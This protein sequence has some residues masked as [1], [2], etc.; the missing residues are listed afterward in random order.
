MDPKALL[1]P[2]FYNDL[3]VS[4]D[5]TIAFSDSSYRYSRSQNR[6]E[7]LDGAPRGRLFQYDPLTAQL[8][9]VLCG[10]HFP[11]GVQFLPPRTVAY[12]ETVVVTDTDESGAEVER[13]EERV[14]ETT[15]QEEVIVNELTRF[16]VLKVNTA[17]ALQNREQLTGSCLEEGGLYQ[18]LAR[19]D[20]PA[21]TRYAKSGV[22]VFID[23]V[24]GLADNVRADPKTSSG[25]G[26][27]YF[28]GLGSKATQPFSLLHVVLQSNLLRE[29]IGRVLPMKL[30]EKLVP[31]YGLVL[32][33]DAAGNLVGSL[34]D[35]SG[36][37]SMISQ[38]DRH[39][40]TGD[41]WLGSHSE[42]LAI[43]PARYV[44]SEW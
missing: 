29:I 24:P 33:S 17:T 11:N 35:P 31:R 6:P 18:A 37:V 10:L 1:A 32:V 26:S 19:A 15:A 44:P 39:P 20:R 43:L 8:S 28:F 5:G 38:A 30:V 36:A 2:S 13:T 14:F 25:G 21:G 27:Y 41:L 16:R 7:I 42:P 22:D 3:D 34:H 12:T 40:L 9:V 23:N 4:I